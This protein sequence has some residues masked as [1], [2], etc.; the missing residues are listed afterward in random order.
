[1]NS[2]S[3]EPASIATS[4]NAET[5]RDSTELVEP[6]GI[7]IGHLQRGPRGVDEQHHVR[8]YDRHPAAVANAL[9]ER[10]RLR[11]FVDDGAD[12]RTGMHERRDVL[13]ADRRPAQIDRSCRRDV[14]LRGVRA[15]EHAGRRAEL[16]DAD[17]GAEIGGAEAER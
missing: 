2:R 17:L 7:T 13:P 12:A 10:R 1:M 16:M 6:F 5:G 3:G 14:A 15:V 9:T 8:K 4:V 11:A